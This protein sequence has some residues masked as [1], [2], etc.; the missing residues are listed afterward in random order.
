LRSECLAPDPPE[1]VVSRSQY[2]DRIQ[3]AL[4]KATPWLLPPSAGLSWETSQIVRSWKPAWTQELTGSPLW[5][6][7]KAQLQAIRDLLTSGNLEDADWE[8]RD[9]FI[10]CMS[11]ARKV[12]L[13]APPIRIRGT[14]ET[15]APQQDL[16]VAGLTELLHWLERL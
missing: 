10:R 11:S 3:T 6:Q 12:S 8:L 2:R 7:A 15:K 16:S 14:V 4:D 5:L 9:L 13:S 1:G